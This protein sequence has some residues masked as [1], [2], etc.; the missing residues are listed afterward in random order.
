[1]NFHHYA[2]LNQKLSNNIFF[3]GPK[4]SFP[5]RPLQYQN[6]IFDVKLLCANV[7]L[8]KG[9]VSLTLLPCRDRFPD[10]PYGVDFLA[11]NCLESGCIVY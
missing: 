7:K 9:D 6:Q 10:T 4:G 5:S 2:H 11:A 1:M 8:T 3:P